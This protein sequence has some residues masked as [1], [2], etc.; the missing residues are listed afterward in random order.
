MREKK[1]YTARSWFKSSEKQRINEDRLFFVKIIYRIIAESVCSA[2]L[3]KVANSTF[4][5]SCRSIVNI[6]SSYAISLSKT[7]LLL[8]MPALHSDFRAPCRLTILKSGCS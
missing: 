8:T 4:L 6:R 2:V 5:C 7:L 1:K 3:E